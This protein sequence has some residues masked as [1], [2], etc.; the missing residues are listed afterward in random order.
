MIT[1]V[2][3]EWVSR[4]MTKCKVEVHHGYKAKGYKEGKLIDDHGAE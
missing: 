2:D 4:T 1:D 3:K